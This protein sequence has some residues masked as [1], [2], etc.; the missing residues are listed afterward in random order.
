MKTPLLLI[1][2]NRPDK[3][4]ELIL[5]LSKIKPQKIYVFCDGPK[6]KSDFVKVEQAKNEIEK[7]SWTKNVST[8]YSQKNNG[9]KYGVIKALDW[10]F[11]NE[12]EGIILEDDCIPNKSF[13][14]FSSQLLDKN[15]NDQ[16]ISLISGTNLG[17][18]D[19]SDN[20]SY[21]FSRNSI[22]W[23]WATWSDRWQIYNKYLNMPRQKLFSKNN[24]KAAQRFGF[25]NK[26]IKNIIKSHKGTIDTWDFL[27]SY[28]NI[29]ENRLSIVPSYNLITNIGFGNGSTH[30][31]IE[32]SLSNLKKQNMPKDI[33]HPTSFVSNYKFDKYITNSHKT[34]YILIDAIG[35]QIKKLFK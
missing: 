18:S 4:K 35:V 17:F 34:L 10:F 27:W 21:F 33:I 13:F 31:K 22:I 23:G 28:F 24:I 7:I 12:K 11:E 16:R 25:S 19:Q 32:T 8:N 1:I 20:S 29:I 30:T 15:R 3:V 14:D 2:Y 26:L 5:S 6:T 9:C